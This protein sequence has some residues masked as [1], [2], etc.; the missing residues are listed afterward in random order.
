MN[1]FWHYIVVALTF[2]LMAIALKIEGQAYTIVN[3]YKLMDYDEIC[4]QIYHMNK[5]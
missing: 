4:H 2:M 5:G 1:I 3:I